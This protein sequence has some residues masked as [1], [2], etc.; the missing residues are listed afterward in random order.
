MKNLYAV[1]GEQKTNTCILYEDIFIEVKF[2]EMQLK[3]MKKIIT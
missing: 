2:V 3:I 1:I